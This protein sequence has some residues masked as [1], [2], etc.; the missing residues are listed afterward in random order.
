[1]NYV[2]IYHIRRQIC[3]RCPS[4][5][6]FINKHP[7]RPPI[8]RKIM[9]S[10]Q[11]HFWSHIL[12][13]PTHRI[14]ELPILQPL[15]KPKVHKLYMST[16]ANQHVFRLQIPIHYPSTMQKRKHIHHLRRIKNCAFFMKHPSSA[17]MSV[18]LSSR[19]VLCN[20][21]QVLWI[22]KSFIKLYNIGAIQL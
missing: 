11:H 20:Q 2:L 18:K 6:H 9:P 1:M 4:N 3:K 12:R 16:G 15:C 17:Q 19:N 13:R 22:L 7:Q 14:R 10:L 21:V 8:R 5:Q